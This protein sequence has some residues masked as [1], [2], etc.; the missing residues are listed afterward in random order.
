MT[1]DRLLTSLNWRPMVGSAVAT[2]VECGQEHRE[3]QAHQD[4]ANLVR[5]QR[6]R[7]RDRRRIADIDDLGRNVRELA[8]NIV[9][10]CC[11]IGGLTAL[12][13][14]LVHVGRNILLCGQGH[15]DG[16]ALCT[17]Q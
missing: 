16:I 10:Q 13:L 2:M 8:A 9:W 6:R 14:V 1:Q 12:P 17:A 4:G 11:L 7:R 3:Q 5:A 15:R